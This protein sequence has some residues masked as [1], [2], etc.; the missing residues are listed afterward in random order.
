M[1]FHDDNNRVNT[2]RLRALLS[3]LALTGPLSIERAARHIG[4]SPRT[5]QRRLADRHLTYR[6]FV[7]E[8]RLETARTLLCRTD[9]SVKDVASMLGYRTASGFSRAFNRWTGKSPRAYRKSTP[10]LPVRSNLAR[11]G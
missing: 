7:E 2:L 4:T 1:I 10:R 5:L 6:T 9:L 3:E 8:V 11:N